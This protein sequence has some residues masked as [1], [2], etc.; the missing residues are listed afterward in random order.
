MLSGTAVFLMLF[1]ATP[2]A[3]SPNSFL[4]VNVPLYLVISSAVVVILAILGWMWQS[5]RERLTQIRTEIRSDLMNDMARRFDEQNKKLEDTF[6]REFSPLRDDI[7]ELPRQMKDLIAAHKQSCG[8]GGN[9]RAA[10]AA[11]AGKR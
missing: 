7:R 11:S 3:A 10:D 9:G 5:S 2:T 6:V 4:L 8:N 1:Q